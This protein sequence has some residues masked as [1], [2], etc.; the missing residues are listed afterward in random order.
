MTIKFDSLVFVQSCTSFKQD[1]PTELPNYH[2][3]E[4]SVGHLGCVGIT[5]C[6]DGGFDILG[7]NGQHFWV[8][9]ANVRWGRKSPHPEPADQCES[10]DLGNPVSPPEPEPVVDPPQEPKGRTKVRTMTAKR[11][12]K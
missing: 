8:A 2:P 4:V 1:S 9:D 5:K 7:E 10:P 3:T 11:R 6:P 12:K